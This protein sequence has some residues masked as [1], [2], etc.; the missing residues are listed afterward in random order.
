VEPAIELD[1]LHKRY[2]DRRGIEDVTFSVEAGELFGFIGPNGAGKTTTIRILLGLLAPTRGDARLFGIPSS[3]AT[4][5]VPVGYVAGETHL[6]P[7]MRAKTLLAYLGAFHADTR[8][9]R[10]AQLAR[11]T[12]LA[13]HF[14]LD[15]DAPTDDLSLGTKKKVA[16][17]AALQHSPALLILDEPTSGL[18]PVIRARLFDELRD[19]VARGA[20][21]L[22][23]SH[24]LS[25]VEVLCRRVAI[26]AEG[27]LVALDDI[28]EL[29]AKSTRR[30]V[31]RFAPGGNS[32]G[33]ANLA[34]RLPGVTRL[35]RHGDA[36]DF[37][38]R[39]QMPPLLDALAASSP[40]DVQIEAPTLSDVFLAD[41][42]RTE[43]HTTGARH[44]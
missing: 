19:E 22:L 27:K 26:V 15:L 7:D 40:L 42:T 31:A 10:A 2:G 21:V 32:D 41:F 18:D 30:V 16:I 4:A 8:A 28:D 13:R 44:A 29:R 33:L 39:G 20:T 3:D 11:R 25:E 34:K 9:R 17:I 6:V 35:E 14:E 24:V 12:R 5:R 36:I 43:S 1:H 38:Y 23:S 37:S